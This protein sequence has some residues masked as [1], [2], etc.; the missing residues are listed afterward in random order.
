[1]AQ[2]TR[3]Q[4][5]K[6]CGVDGQVFRYEYKLNGQKYVLEYNVSKA[7]AIVEAVPRDPI[8]VRPELAVEA[9][10][11]VTLEHVAHVETKFPAIAVRQDRKLLFID[12]NHRVAAWLCKREPVKTY[13][14]TARERRV[15]LSS[16]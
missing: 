9:L 8:I 15:I 12:G 4:W 1:M 5:F 14:L 7:R 6:Q 16:K 3:C 13:L 10:G 11:I 2:C